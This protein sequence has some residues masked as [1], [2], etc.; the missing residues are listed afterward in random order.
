MEI[1]GITRLF[2]ILA[3]PIRQVKTP[4]AINRMM[5]E[6]GVNGV[7][8]PM[9]VGAS[10]LVACFA[11]LRGMKNLG[12]LIATVP[13]KQAIAKLCD[14]ISEAAAAVGAV[15]V[16]RRHADGRMV[17]D[18][19]DGQGFVHGL[20][21]HGIEP[22]GKRVFLAGAGGAACAI[23][24][25][26][27]QAG[28]EHL[29]IH[30]RTQSK[31]SELMARLR[32]HHVSLSVSAADASPVGFDLI[33]N[34]T[35]LGMNATDPLPFDGGAITPDQVVADIIMSPEVTPLL[36]LARTRGCKVQFGAPMLKAQIALMAQ[37]MGATENVVEGDDVEV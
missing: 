30:N 34:A 7:M 21:E 11:A 8:V 5:R 28:V 18:I 19:L 24:F 23:A 1:N 27:A 33:V 31:V 26:L 37:F 16:V 20:R 29:G 15:N 13:H 25:A 32:D 36:A 35:S 6:L 12:G 9:H 10:N 22:E 2:A 17:G 14:E 4:Q 3:D